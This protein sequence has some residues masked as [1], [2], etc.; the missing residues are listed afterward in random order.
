[1]HSSVFRYFR[2]DAFNAADPTSIK[3]RLCLTSSTVEPSAARSRRTSSGTSAHI[4][5]EHQSSSVPTTPVA[6]N[7]SIIVPQ[8]ISV[9][10]YLGR[11]DWQPN[12]KDRVFLRGNGFTFKN[13]QVVAAGNTDPS[14]FYYA[15]RMNYGFLASWNRQISSKMVNEL[16]GGLSHFQWQNLPDY[17]TQAIT[18]AG[19]KN[20]PDGTTGGALTIGGP[21]NYPQI[22]YQNVQQYRDDVYYLTGKHSIKAGV[23]YMHTGHSGY[24]QQNVRGTVGSANCAVVDYKLAFP[25]GTMTRIAGTTPSSIALARSQPSRRDPETSTSIFRA[26]RSLSGC[27]TI[28]SCSRA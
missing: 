20:R 15:T 28:G 16:H 18:F 4:E 11:G 17:P 25:N 6:T 2:N 7:S 26:T 3:S 13:D 14:S 19:V 23:E 21:Y 22:F 10:E 12:Q 8:T 5:G 24:F 9:N 27:R 1:M